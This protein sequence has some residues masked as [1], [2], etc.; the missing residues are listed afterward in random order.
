[1]KRLMRSKLIASILVNAV[2]PMKTYPISLINTLL[3]PLSLIF[4]VT[5]I[6]GG[7]LIGIA[8][9]GGFI[10]TMISNGIG[11]QPDLAHLKNDLKIQDMVVSSPTSALL[12]M[13]GMSFSELVYAIPAIVVLLILSVFF[14]HIGFVSA[15][16]VIAVMIATFIFS[17]SAGFFLSTYASDVMESY[18][19][20]GVLSLIL[21]TLP[22]VY[23][24]LSYIPLPFRYLAYLSPTTYVAQLAQSAAGFITISSANII[25]DWMIVI[26]ISATL[27]ALAVKKSHWRE[28]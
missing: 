1:M 14:L 27:M 22:P 18:A 23:Y 6:S 26:A 21:S 24:P 8:I 2:Y 15:V 3:A 9:E 13:V 28:N 12:Y 16:A 19:Y 4:V 25:L 10:A 5:I 11:M 17:V 20:M 7:N